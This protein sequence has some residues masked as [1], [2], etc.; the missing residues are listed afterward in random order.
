MPKSVAPVPVK[1]RSGVDVPIV[2]LPQ[3]ELLSV[4]LIDPDKGYWRNQRR[5]RGRWPMP[6][7]TG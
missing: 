3:Q 2:S 4:H 1:T 5:E 6:Q 7:E